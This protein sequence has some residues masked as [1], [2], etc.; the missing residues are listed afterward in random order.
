MEEKIITREANLHDLVSIA[1]ENVEYIEEQK[2]AQFS[3][4][5]HAVVEAVIRGEIESVDISNYGKDRPHF[6]IGNN[7]HCTSSAYG[8]EDV[9]G[10]IREA[11]G[12]KT[13]EAEQC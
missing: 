5:I 6:Y 9:E 13:E 8:I 2:K 12:E 1:K 3:R 7:G 10:V 4:A 11:L